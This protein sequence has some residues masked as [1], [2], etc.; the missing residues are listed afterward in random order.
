MSAPCTE[1]QSGKDAFADISI[2]VMETLSAPQ[3][4]LRLFKKRGCD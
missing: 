1:Y 2:R 3:I 4:A